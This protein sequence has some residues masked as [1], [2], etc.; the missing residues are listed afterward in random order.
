MIFPHEFHRF[1]LKTCS[2]EVHF[3]IGLLFGMICIESIVLFFRVIA[4]HILQEPFFK[5]YIFY[6]FPNNSI[7]LL[8][9]PKKFIM[10]NAINIFKCIML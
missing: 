8:W 2:S 1:Y 4:L 7:K 9:N 3:L 10:I 6:K 5:V